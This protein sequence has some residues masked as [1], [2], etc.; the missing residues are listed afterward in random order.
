M[1]WHDG[2]G[3][4]YDMEETQGKVRHISLALTRAAGAGF[5]V[6][7]VLIAAGAAPALI[8]AA[9][10]AGTALLLLAHAQGFGAWHIETEAMARAHGFPGFPAPR[11]PPA[12]EKRS[13]EPDLT[14]PPPRLLPA[15]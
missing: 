11:I 9:A 13:F 10:L 7:F 4:I 5:A 14:S 12:T 6:F 1:T 3:T 2:L 8:I 15:I